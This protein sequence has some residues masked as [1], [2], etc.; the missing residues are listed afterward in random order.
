MVNFDCFFDWYKSELLDEYQI[1]DDN[2]N[3][4]N[5]ELQ[6]VR[7]AISSFFGDSIKLK[8]VRDQLIAI[9]NGVDLPPMCS[10]KWR[11]DQYH[12]IWWLLTLGNS[13]ICFRTA[14]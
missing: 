2:P 13:E 11:N 10:G 6:T 1:K 5:K 8:I 7:L 4:V 12:C 14:P 9:K 3:Y